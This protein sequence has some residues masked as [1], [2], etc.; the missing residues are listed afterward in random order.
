MVGFSERYP[1]KSTIL[2]SHNFRSRSE[3]L[4]AATHCV[5]HNQRRVPKALVAVRGSGGLVQ[6][7]GFHQDWHE[8]YWVAAEVADAIA[9]RVPGPEILILARTGY[10]T[11]P[12]QLALARAGIPHRVL[13]SLGLYERTEVK[14]ALAYLTLLVNPADAQAFRR[15]VQSPRRGVGPATASAIVTRAREE[16][17]G[18]LPLACARA[19]ET[20]NVR[21]A[22]TRQ[23]L[24]SFGEV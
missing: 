5:A 14:D 9:A 13:G 10:A 3:I 4:E 18:D 15:A 21:S 2:L 20:G 19:D 23:R 11:Q 16:R 24:S 22:E 12:M 7:R 17:H 8:A 6:L 1:R